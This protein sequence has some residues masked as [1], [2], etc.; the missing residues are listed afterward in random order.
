MEA[1]GPG[2]VAVGGNNNAPITT[3]VIGR[4]VF[5]DDIRITHVGGDVTISVDRP[6]YRV[7]PA[8]IVPVVIS[9][10]QARAQ[11]SRLLLARHQ[12]VPFTGR[13]RAL[14][15]LATWMTD[16]D[17]VSARLIHAAGG[18]GK[19]R[20]A[21]EVS[22]RYARA[23]WTV[24][25]VRYTPVSVPGR[26]IT[27]APASRVELTSGA[28]LVVVDYA[29]RWPFSAV[30]ALLTQLR[31]LHAA[32]STKV[33]V[34]LLARSAGFWWQAIANRADSDLDIQADQIALPSLAADSADDRQA[35]YRVAATRFAN[36]LDVPGDNWSAP[37]LSGD[38][39]A[40]VLAVHM[41]ALA[42][43]DAHR[44]GYV[45]PVRPH[46]VSSYLLRREQAHWQEIHAW[47]EP[48]MVTPPQVMHRTAFTATLTGVLPRLAARQALLCTAL[49]SNETGAD[50]IIDD[51]RACYPPTAP[52][53][54]LEPV[55]PDRLGED[56][57]ALSTPGHGHD[58][59][60][61]LTDDW[62]LTTPDVLLSALGQ[63][64]WAPAVV[65]TLVET[66]YRWPH[67]RT[68]QLYSLVRHRPD[69][70]ITA[71]G[72]TLTRLAG[73]PDVD[74][75]ILEILESHLPADRHIDLDIAAAAITEK[76]VPYRLR[77][78]TDPVVH[79]QLHMDYA[80][81]LSNAGQ[82]T[83]A[84]L[85]YEEATAVYRQL[86][87]TDPA[88]HLSNLAMSL[89]NL[90]SMLSQLGNHDEALIRV[91]E[92]I[93]ILRPLAKR[94]PAAHLPNLA[95][96]VGNLGMIRS[97]LGHDHEAL[98][99]MEEAVVL[100]RKLARTDPNEHQPNLAVSLTNLG[101]MLDRL[102]RH[103]DA[104]PPAEEAVTIYRRLAKR[105]AAVYSPDLATSLTNFG[106]RLSQLGEYQLALPP[107]EEAVTIFRQLARK[108]PNAY[109]HGF[110]VSL[111]NLSARSLQLGHHAQALTASEEAVSIN[112]R[113]AETNPAVHLPRLA[114]ALNNLGTSLK[115]SGRHREALLSTQEA[116]A[117]SRRMA[118]TNPMIYLPELAGQLTNLAS[119]LAHIGLYE[120]ALAP[121]EESASIYRR[122]SETAPDAHARNAA[123]SL[124][125]LG[126]RLS[127]LGRQIEA[128]S[129]REEAAALYRRLAAKN[130]KYLPA[131]AGA[132]TDLVASYFQLGRYR[133]ALSPAEEATSISRQSVDANLADN[134]PQLAMSLINLGGVRTQLGLP[135]AAPT[136]EEAVAVYRTLANDDSITYLPRLAASLNNLGISLFEQGRLEE[137]ALAVEEGIDIY[138]RVG[139]PDPIT[140][141]PELAAALTNLATWLPALNRPQ[142]ALASSKNAI[143][144]SRRLAEV[145][146]A[147]HA[148][149]LALSL[150]T[151]ASVCVRVN[152]DL[153]IALTA[154][155]EAIE[156]YEQLF[157]GNP[158]LF[159]GHALA[160]YDT[161]AEL[162]DRVGRL[163]EAAELRAKLQHVRSLRRPG[164]NPNG[165][166]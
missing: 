27:T 38:D 105:D 88:V 77:H 34:L 134:L 162:L 48:P 70:V 26:E 142:E 82:H 89:A 30:L 79:A 18:Q 133:D 146:P 144:I 108:N 92:A 73:I 152:A 160:A 11:P 122:L 135:D 132:L 90:G 154:I 116:V 98:L 150:R 147:V 49:A 84:V 157:E 76:T 43:V 113:L 143:D 9:A 141:L 53:T 5:G 129:P 161:R 137:A 123:V 125:N 50:Q 87:R 97:G 121:A 65:T 155:D 61:G 47:S 158:Q 20:L 56:L 64:Q 86:A 75:E 81:R 3:T 66:A 67:V 8:V 128:L 42:A 37:D 25:Q 148:P 130:L 119:L 104:L 35:L 63:K 55:H 6:V 24:W 19:S 78:T 52:T 57:I 136:V 29:D 62:T 68:G 28:L 124:T 60:P 145:Q 32:A 10:S 91:E 131:L 74:P 69:L 164:A 109:L 40:Q 23:G 85:E 59:L 39:F 112:R 149:S 58:D 12:V 46:A 1:S 100:N 102:G 159:A 31:Q 151:Y 127:Q 22:A 4:V 15:E 71:G 165:D 111:S 33:R 51:H 96:S 72:A 153:P 118:A 83:K 117:I 101:N 94:I 103:D 106:I 44:H 139:V 107:T 110:S 54:V 114:S 21:D 13:D 16:D 17:T 126:I 115:E 14:E 156:L 7:T 80:R 99:L 140:Y 120:D 93:I 45:P 95:S 41:T 2:A 163:A 166:G 36:A 138:Q